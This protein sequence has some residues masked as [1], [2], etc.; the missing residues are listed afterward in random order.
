MIPKSNKPYI[1]KLRNIQLT[2]ADYNGALKYIIGRKLRKYSEHNGSSSD[3]TFGG[4]S[5]RNC[6]Q[7]L[8]TIQTM[9]EDNR[10][11]YIPQAHLD[12]DAVGCFDNMATNLIGLAIQRIGGDR[13]I[14]MAQ[15]KALVKRKHRVKTSLGISPGFFS[16][17]EEEK[18]GGSGQGSGASIINWH[19]FN[20]A[21]IE[22]YTNL[23]NID[24]Y[25]YEKDY[26]VKS[27]VDDNKLLFD[28]EGD[29]ALSQIKETLLRGIMTWS[30]LLHFTGGEL[31]I[32]KCFF[33]VVMYDQ[34]NDGKTSIVCHNDEEQNLQVQLQNGNQKIQYV[35]PGNGS[36][37]LGVRMSTSGNFN[38]EHSFR[39]KQS[40]EMAALL[41]RSNLSRIE[42]Y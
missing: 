11:K 22:S 41:T 34:K 7:M 38:E 5:K 24:K 20:E 4:R 16:W 9:N 17:S 1:S 26:H 37:L 2:E 19:S 25:K 31:S 39:V 3:N 13:N 33:S 12:I 40:H 29:T 42:A 6:I 8:K 23:M 32:P 30:K 36:R 18:I 35:N 27:F 21:I 14:A 15:T 28:F 10:L